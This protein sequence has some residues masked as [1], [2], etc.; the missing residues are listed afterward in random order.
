M[1][2]KPTYEELQRRI[3]ELEKAEKER[4]K[5]QDLLNDEISWRRILV[6]QSRDGIVVL[7]RNARVYEANQRFADMLGYTMEEIH[8]L[9]VWDW[10]IEATKEQVLEMAR[11]VDESGHHFETR[12]RHKDGKIIDVELSNNGA[13]YRGQKLIFCVCRDITDRKQAEKER[14]KLIQELK[15]AL[16][17]ITTLR[18]ILP[19][20]SFCK[21]VRNDEG[22]WEQ[23]DVYLQKYSQADISHSICPECIRKHYPDLEM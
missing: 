8:R 6:E 11:A 17:E 15:E 9:H 20:C 13:V 10:D 23:V 1:P 3:L 21:K 16:D 19:I 14:E 2:D 12:H 5:T 7:D 22:F 4:Q 18:G